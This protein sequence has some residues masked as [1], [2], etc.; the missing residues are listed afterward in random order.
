MSKRRATH[1][2]RSS[3]WTCGVSA[4]HLPRRGLEFL[5]SRPCTKLR[6]RTA[7]PSPR[8]RAKKRIATGPLRHSAGE[9]ASEGCALLPRGVSRSRCENTLRFTNLPDA[10]AISVAQFKSP[11]GKSGRPGG[12]PASESPEAPQGHRGPRQ[13]PRPRGSN[14]LVRAGTDPHRLKGRNLLEYSAVPLE[15]RSP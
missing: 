15:V 5:Q 12:A 13:V 9:R 8:G 11:G 10:S 6:A 1:Q 3:D 7:G 4:T 2:Q 14:N